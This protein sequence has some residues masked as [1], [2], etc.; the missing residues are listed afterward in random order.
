MTACNVILDNL[1]PSSSKIRRF[2]RKEKN[3][4]ERERERETE[5]EET[6]RST[7][8]FHSHENCSR[9]LSRPLFRPDSPRAPALYIRA[10]INPAVAAPV[11]AHSADVLYPTT[12][13]G[14]LGG[15][16][17][18]RTAVNKIGKRHD[19]LRRRGGSKGFRSISRKR[20]CSMYRYT[21]TGAS[22]LVLPHKLDSS[23][24][25]V[26]TNSLS[27]NGGFIVPSAS[28][29]YPRAFTSA[30]IHCSSA[31]PRAIET[32]TY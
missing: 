8:R 5:K 2:S 31:R 25:S 3:A 22:F 19:D 32:S 27:F 30:G 7:R 9:P 21:I 24:P 12:P 16:R 18:V 6:A 4:C 1:P 20:G 26:P 29:K 10:T 13:E 17:A 14:S 28:R 11:R 23:S 15:R